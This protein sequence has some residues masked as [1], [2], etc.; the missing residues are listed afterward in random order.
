MAKENAFTSEESLPTIFDACVAFEN[1]FALLHGLLDRK[2]GK[3]SRATVVVVALSWKT[4]F[5]CWKPLPQSYKRLPRGSEQFKKD[6]LVEQFS[7]VL[8]SSGL[9]MCR[10]LGL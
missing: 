2:E 6:H 1:L 4:R 7:H 5:L 8:F 9:L 3:L 10:L